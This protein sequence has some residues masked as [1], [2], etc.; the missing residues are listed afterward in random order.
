MTTTRFGNG[1]KTLS[2]ASKDSPNLPDLKTRVPADMELAV[3]SCLRRYGSFDKFLSKLGVDRQSYLVANWKDDLICV[4]DDGNGHVLVP[5]IRIAALAFGYEKIQAWL[6]TYLVNLNSFLLGSNPEKKMTG[7]QIEEAAAVI[8]DNYGQTI[9]VTEVPLIFSR[10]KA[11]KYGKSYGVIDG[12][13]VLNCIQLYLDG[14]PLEKAEILKIKERKRLREE[15]ERD[16]MKPRM[17]LDEWRQTMRYAELKSIGLV[18]NIE[19]FAKKFDLQII[20]D[21]KQE[22]QERDADDVCGSEVPEQT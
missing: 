5:N 9:F 14:R 19:A 3:G 7:S 20:G 18:D 13:M 17:S 1:E 6:M 10:I 11:G 8:I 16:A 15:A 4:P 12:G 2:P 21:A 22:N